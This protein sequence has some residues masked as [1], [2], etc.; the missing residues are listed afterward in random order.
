MSKGILKFRVSVVLFHSMSKLINSH[1]LLKINGGEIILFSPREVDIVEMEYTNF[2]YQKNKLKIL[3]PLKKSSNY[4]VA[5]PIWK[6]NSDCNFHSKIIQRNILALSS[7]VF[8]QNRQLSF[9]KRSNLKD[10]ATAIF[11][12]SMIGRHRSPL[13]IVWLR[14]DLRSEFKYSFLRVMVKWICDVNI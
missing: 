14:I 10:F 12:Y 2:Y 11:L 6:I 3:I 5:Y 4:L 9:S 7:K 1:Y 8:V 13:L